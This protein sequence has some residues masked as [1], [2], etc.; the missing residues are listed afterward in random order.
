MQ[1]VRP[2]LDQANWH[3]RPSPVSQLSDALPES[4]RHT[5]ALMA[6]F[7]LATY[8]NPDR[9]LTESGVNDT[10]PMPQVEQSRDYCLLIGLVGLV[11]RS[12]QQGRSR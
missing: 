1:G 8:L 5:L 7:D 4:C 9:S 6:P 2:Q 3:C 12:A 11:P 10:L